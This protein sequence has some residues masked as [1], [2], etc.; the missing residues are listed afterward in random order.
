MEN[1]DIYSN[2]LAERYSSREMLHIF[3]PQFKFRTW[4]QLWINLAEVEKELGLDFITDEQIEEAARCGDC[5]HGFGHLRHWR[6]R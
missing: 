4:R 1:M 6:A 2:P 5:G 3:S